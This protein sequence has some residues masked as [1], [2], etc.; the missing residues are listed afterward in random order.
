MLFEFKHQ[1]LISTGSG[2]FANLKAFLGNT[3]Q[4]C[5]SG[6]ANSPRLFIFAISNILDKFS[7]GV[8]IFILRVKWHCNKHIIFCYVRTSPML[9]GNH[10]FLLWLHCDSLSI[11]SSSIPWGPVLWQMGK[12]ASCDASI[13]YRCWFKPLLL[14]FWYNSL[15]MCLRKHRRSSKSLCLCTHFGYLED[16]PSFWLWIG[17]V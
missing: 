13:P 10:W 1:L 12:A 16:T 14:Q 17:A 7:S 8:F 6:G 4:Q 15:L 3:V 11:D 9:F 2:T 5:S